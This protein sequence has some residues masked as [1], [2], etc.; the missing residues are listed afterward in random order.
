MGRG[1]P[2]SET[3]VLACEMRLVD[4]GRVGDGIRAA[5]GGGT[6]QIGATPWGRSFH[7]AVDFGA[8]LH[9]VSPA[10][11]NFFFGR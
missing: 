1:E 6:F 10:A 3:V 11:A 8:G 7:V 5:D 2:R 4:A 9:I